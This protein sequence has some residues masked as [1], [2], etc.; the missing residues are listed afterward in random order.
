MKENPKR[1]IAVGVEP[2]STR[3]MSPIFTETPDRQGYGIHKSPLDFCATIHSNRLRNKSEKSSKDI[4]IQQQAKINSEQPVDKFNIQNIDYTDQL[5]HRISSL[6]K[7]IQEKNQILGVMK[8]E[9][10][11]NNKEIM[12]LKNQNQFVV[13]QSAHIDDLQNL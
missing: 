6:E 12:F 9:K 5:L 10:I 2:V 4:T 13:S 11:E 3:I 1:A 8:K 7:C